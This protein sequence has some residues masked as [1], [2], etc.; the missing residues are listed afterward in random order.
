MDTF[1]RSLN[2]KQYK[3]PYKAIKKFAKYK[4]DEEW[5]TTI[6]DCVELAL[7]NY[8]IVELHPPYNMLHVRLRLLQLIEACYL[9]DIRTTKTKKALA[10]NKIIDDV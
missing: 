10:K 3:D 5:K 1:P 7:S 8:S 9:L 4:S 6:D 2:A